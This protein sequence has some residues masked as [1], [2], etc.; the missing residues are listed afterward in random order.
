MKLARQS[1]QVWPS[2]PEVFTHAGFIDM[3]SMLSR[4][5]WARV[6][7]FVLFMV[8]LALRG[9]LPAE[10]PWLDT[11]WVYGLSVLVVGGSLAYFWRQYSELGP[12]AKPSVVHL[13]VAVVVGAVVF[14][15]W[16]SLTEPWMMLGRPT[17]SFRPVD[18]DGQLQWGLIAVRWIGA[19]LL[20]PVME[21]LFW[22]SF[23]MRWI[24]NPDFE[25]VDPAAVSPKAM[26]LSTLVFMLAHTQWLG[27][28]VAG[29]AYAWLYRYTRSLWVPILAHAVTNG[30]LGIWVVVY[31][32]WQFW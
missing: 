2:L 9:Y 19:S 32:N 20:V 10:T 18:P 21:E 8:L 22:R 25:K 26:A 14:K 31:G 12:G 3:E 15:L 24:D 30:V 28:I 5:A 29:L 7:P 11:R 23:L 4:A 27:A 16:I 6:I 1:G 17:A 13:L